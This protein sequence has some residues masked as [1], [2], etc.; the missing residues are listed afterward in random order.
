[1][2]IFFFKNLNLNLKSYLRNLSLILFHETI[3]ILFIYLNKWLPKIELKNLLSLSFVSFFGILSFVSLFNQ[4]INAVINYK[5]NYYLHYIE[6]IF[7]FFLLTSLVNFLHTLKAYIN[8]ISHFLAILQ[9]PTWYL[10]IREFT[11]YVW[12][13]QE[14]SQQFPFSNFYF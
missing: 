4:V 5:T 2:I 14:A 9:L 1:L 13:S 10:S 8:Y 11:C 7:S 6:L 12:F 3:S